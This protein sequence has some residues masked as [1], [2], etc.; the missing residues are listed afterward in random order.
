MYICFVIQ[1]CPGL[2]MNCVNIPDLESRK[3]LYHMYKD[4]M[5][6]QSTPWFDI[7]GNY[8]ERLK[9]AIAFINVVNE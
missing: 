8:E 2:Q 3:R 4:L 5:I 1:T 7:S 6:N 9:K